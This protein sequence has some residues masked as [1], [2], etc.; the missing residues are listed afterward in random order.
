M[1]LISK[2]K[3]FLESKSLFNKPTFGFETHNQRQQYDMNDLNDLEKARIITKN[4]PN[5]LFL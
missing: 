1:V 5:I 3:Y 2:T 4:Y